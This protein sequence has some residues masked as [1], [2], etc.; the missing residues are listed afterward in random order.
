MDEE[1]VDIS[2]DEEERWLDFVESG[3]HF[4]YEKIEHILLRKLLS[5][6]H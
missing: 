4:Q 3:M 5:T 2:V 1:H 6:I